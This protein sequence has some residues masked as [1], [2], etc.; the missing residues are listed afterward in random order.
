MKKT[1]FRLSAL[2][3]ALVMSLALL[4]GCK[5]PDEGK[6]PPDTP[7]IQITT[8]IYEIAKHGNLV[9]Y[10][11][12]SDLYDK[13]FEHGDI[14][15]IAI[16]EKKWDAPLCTSYSDV[17]NGEVVLRANGAKDG[18]VLAINMGDFAT[19][20]GIAKKTAIE[21]EPGY[22]WDYLMETPVEITITM[23]EEGGYRE[24]WLIRQLVRTNE[25]ADYSHLSDE[26]FANFRVIETT[27]MGKGVLYRSSS[28]INPDLG[29]STYADKAAE[30]AG[31][32]T[33][34]NLADSSNTYS[35]TENTYYST[36][37]VAYVN[38]GTDFLSESTLRGVAEGMRFIINNNGPYLI[39]CNEGK[40]RAGFV[41]ALLECLMGAT[42]DEVIDDYM[43]TYY[44]YYGV[45]KG[46][47]KY[48]VVVKNNLIKSLNEVFKVEDVYKA[49]LA[50]EAE[51]YLIEDAGLTG[52]EVSALKGRLTI[53]LQEIYN[54]S[55]TE[56]LLKNHESVYIRNESDGEF[57]RET[58][59]TKDYSYDYMPDEVLPFLNFMTDD[60]NYYY[61]AGHRLR[62]FF[63]TPDGVGDFVKGREEYYSLVIL[64]EECLD[65]IIESVIQKDGRITVKTVMSQKT[66]DSLVDFGVTS[67]RCEYVLDAKTREIISVFSSYTFVDG[68]V[69]DSVIE[70]SYDVEMPEVLKEFLENVNSTED[71]RNVTIVINPGTDKEEIKSIQA[72]G[73]MVIGFEFDIVTGYEIEF[74]TDAAC[75]EAYDPYAGTDSDLTVYVKWVESVPEDEIR[76]TVTAEEWEALV[77]EKNYTWERIDNGEIYT[78]QKYT[79]YAMDID[80]AVYLYIDD[81]IYQLVEEEDGWFAYDCT[82]LEL[83]HLGLL[84]TFDMV[85]FEYDES[86]QAY[87]YKHWEEYGYK[88][89]L[90]FENGIH[91]SL[92]MIEVGNESNVSVRLVHNVGTTVIEIPEYTIVEDDFDYPVYSYVTEEVWNSFAGG[93][94]FEYYV[95]MSNFIGS[96]FYSEV[97]TVKSVGNA[98]SVDDVIYVLED[99]KYYVLEET[100]SG[101]IATESELP[102]FCFTSLLEGLSYN[103]FDF[104]ENTGFFVPKE[105]VEEDEPYSEVT[106]DEN[107]ILLT[108][109]IY[110]D[111]L[112][113]NPETEGMDLSTVISF[114]NIGTTVISVP[115]Y[116][117]VR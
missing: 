50:K 9:L 35:G 107:G 39:H 43:V 114:S 30:N 73:G 76:Y 86:K 63:V 61:D 48:D 42:I 60:A 98:I 115:E 79:E 94:N 31:I 17:D 27:G 113:D 2:V 75:T 25:R 49:D 33:V 102:T 52:D 71:L 108:L 24:E 59:L 40:D 11:Y 104:D 67:G 85:D 90:R 44:N 54:A 100:A 32:I 22:R 29:R 66:I 12:G 18:V 69:S 93:T 47:E 57:W 19:T 81:K 101:W 87:L 89:E 36:C 10:M 84:E 80:G 55:K 7:P 58:Y 96:D 21:E 65:D 5:D 13:G 64:G 83:W 37:N 70:M 4:V 97:H 56:D 26:A 45:E 34:V 111:N 41:S 8:T 103:D 116:T 51:A 62:Y 99:G 28:P 23:K 16:G 91:T 74:Y 1:I 106:F 15:E 38:L 46:T 6:N 110:N 105:D 53:T 72:P 3:L 88:L 78:I 77:N 95:F 109:F 92:T 68:T 14:V 82:Y 112:S 20:A 117:V